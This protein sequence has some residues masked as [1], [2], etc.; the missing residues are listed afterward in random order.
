MK[1][2][3]FIY[4]WL[5][6]NILI[7]SIY[8]LGG[9]DRINYAIL[10]Y[11]YYLS[12]KLDFSEDILVIGIT[13]KC[14][15]RLGRWPWDRTYYLKLFSILKK[16]G[17]KAVGIDIL[18]SEPEGQVDRQLAEI[19][20]ELGKVVYSAYFNR[21]DSRLYTPIPIISQNAFGVG[22]IN[23]TSAI[24]GFIYGLPVSLPYRNE[25]IKAFSIKV[26]EAYLDRVIRD[27]PRE[28]N[29]LLINYTG[30]RPEVIA[31]SD[32]L[33][34]KIPNEVFKD[35]LV[36]VGVTA[37]GLGD[38][39]LVPSYEEPI[40]ELEIHTNAVNTI[41]KG[42]FPKR[43]PKRT[44]VI[45]TL[46][47]ALSFLSMK[48]RPIRILLLGLLTILI[49]FRASFTLFS[50]GRIIFDCFPI[51]LSTIS[52]ITISTIYGYFKDKKKVIRSN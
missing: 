11:F 45:I 52:N 40:S 37:K 14:L 47:V 32:V 33:D 31:F 4:I 13:D 23:V 8:S 44:V 48:E 20:R 3:G 16:S 39:F 34:G 51:I 10:N 24:N 43:I 50:P 12:S 15:E 17:A 18:F 6:A 27:M 9:F 49:S 38:Y 36:L 26:S 21:E 28:D 41:I 22:H 1:P 29:N 35:K 7:V 5:I 30:K 2:K 25:E 19:S 42:A 46:I